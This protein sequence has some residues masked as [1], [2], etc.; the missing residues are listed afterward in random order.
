MGWE[1][2]RPVAIRSFAVIAI[3]LLAACSTHESLVT[4][5]APLSPASSVRGARVMERPCFHYI[6]GGSERRRASRGAD[7]RQRRQSL[8]DDGL[9]RQPKLSVLFRF[10]L[11]RR[12]QDR[13]QRY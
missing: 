8:W 10:W 12:L 6:S 5:A 2:R 13:S 11:R 1:S 9:R 4:P 3:A 7:A